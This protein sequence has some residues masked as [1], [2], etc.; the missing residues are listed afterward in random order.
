MKKTLVLF[1][2][3]SSILFSG[4]AN[5]EKDLYDENRAL[6]LQEEAKK[7]QEDAEIKKNAEAIFGKI[8]SEHNWQSF[9]EGTV[10][11]KADAPL[12]D[13]VKVQIL[14]ESPFFNQEAKVLN[15][16]TVKK[17]QTVQMIYASPNI[18][19]NLV[20]ACIDSKGNYYIQVFDKNQ[21]EVKFS[22]DAAAK[23]NR[24]ALA[25]NTPSFTQLILKAPRKSFNTMRKEQGENCVIDNTTYNN[26]IDSKWNDE[27]WEVADGQSFDNGWTLDDN[28][29]IGHIFHS[30]DGFD[31]GQLENVKMIV[32]N[33]F[34]KYTDLEKKQKKNNI[35]IVR[36]S[37][38]FIVNSN[39]VI[40]TGEEPVVLIPIQA[41]TDEFKMNHIY[42][43]YYRSED[44]PA[45][46]SEE[47]YIKQLPKFK[48]I[49]IERV[50]TTV[51]KNNGEFYR[52]Q[53]FLLPYYKNSPVEG[54]NEASAIFPA[55]Y[56]IGV[57]NQKYGNGQEKAWYNGNAGCTYGFG[58]LNKE[59]NHIP[60]FLMAMDNSLGGTIKDGMTWN[61]PRIAIFTANKKTYMTFE[62]GSD[63]NFSDMLFEIGGGIEQLD[64]TITIEAASYTMCFEDRLANADY[65]MNDVV[66][67]ATRVNETKIKLAVIAC[68]A[69]DELMIQGLPEGSFL[70]SKEVHELFN[71]NVSYGFIN[72]EKD[73]TYIEPVTEEFD[74]DRNTSIIDFLKNITIKNLTT[75]KT[76]SLPKTGEPPYA[77]IVPL[78]FRYP[79]E[80]KCIKAVYPS[81]QNWANNR[82]VDTE[83][84]LF[85]SDDLSYPDKFNNE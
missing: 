60:H 59:V 83:W 24:R 5:R 12:D 2:A 80:Q 29:N 77:I 57:L 62:E 76:V 44:I 34:Y 49:Q 74:I 43:Y 18:Y 69:S 84:Y 56:K 19:T 20:A 4:C 51:E 63:C 42:Y 10:S 21:S 32:N 79:V 30:V 46:M 72:T 3:A 58:E 45:G 23:V 55:G 39:N 36:N 27:M 67:R 38:N 71:K 66:L 33:F 37:P 14:T 75:G 22:S 11:I 48:A 68:G 50:Q 73:K 70:G 82:N 31:N 53:A 61:D 16:A 81:F 1:L 6:Q 28:R 52:R 35:N 78:S 25:D 13:I 15:E 9:Y 26:W 41:Y 47:D 8:D 64:E 85:G 7:L 54:V 65:D 40:T 17:G